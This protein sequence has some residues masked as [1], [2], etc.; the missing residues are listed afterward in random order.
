MDQEQ[1]DTTAELGSTLMAA[2]D[3][4]KVVLKD[5]AATARVKIGSIW[6]EDVPIVTARMNENGEKVL[7]AVHENAVLLQEQATTAMIRIGDEIKANVPIYKE[8]IKSG[9]D[10]AMEEIRVRVNEI[11]DRTQKGSGKFWGRV[12]GKKQE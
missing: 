5:R 2:A 4:V 11:R 3:D 6:H 12:F 1:R 7:K 10:G 8:R 9:A